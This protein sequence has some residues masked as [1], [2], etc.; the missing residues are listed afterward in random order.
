MNP[1]D[2]KLSSSTILQD[3]GALWLRDT[4]SR[5]ERKLDLLLKTALP[6]EQLIE[7]TQTVDG[8]KSTSDALAEEIEQNKQKDTNAS[9]PATIN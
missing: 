9:R 2:Q 6:P 1:T 5:M 7:L 3:L 4:L 8:A